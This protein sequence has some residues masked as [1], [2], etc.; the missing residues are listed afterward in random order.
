MI[1]R[2][3]YFD[4][5]FK[6]TVLNNARL[7]YFSAEGEA[8][9]SSQVL[10]MDCLTSG[11]EDAGVAVG[12]IFL[13]FLVLQDTLTAD[14]RLYGFTV[15]LDATSNVLTAFGLTLARDFGSG[16]TL[17]LNVGGRDFDSESCRNF[18]LADPQTDQI[19][20]ITVHWNEVILGISLKVGDREGSFGNTDTDNSKTYT[21][22][23]EA[24]LIGLFGYESPQFLI[25]LNFITLDTVSEQCK[26]VDPNAVEP[27]GD[28]QGTDETTEN[29][30][31]EPIEETTEEPTEEPIEEPTE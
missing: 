10:P 15:C 3:L 23:P 26:Y 19:D 17:S 25:G 12:N 24:P 29:S 5:K 30:A 9:S 27:D 1:Y 7:S 28:D 14:M 4:T 22:E 21:F 11:S 6:I 18:Q 13:D 16:E 2:H 20:E 8:S 31:E